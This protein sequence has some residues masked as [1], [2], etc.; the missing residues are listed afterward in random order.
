MLGVFFLLLFL[1]GNPKIVTN[2]GPNLSVDFDI[3]DFIKL[4]RQVES[5]VV[6][7]ACCE[8]SFVELSDVFCKLL[9][10][11]IVGKL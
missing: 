9:Y 5:D 4:F 8:D 1:N 10:L 6:D 3:H 2:S 7:L 11:G